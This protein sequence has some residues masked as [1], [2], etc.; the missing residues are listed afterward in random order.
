MSPMVTGAMV[1]VGVVGDHGASMGAA[2]IS[3]EG[4]FGYAID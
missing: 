1:D 2:E 4:S 3:P